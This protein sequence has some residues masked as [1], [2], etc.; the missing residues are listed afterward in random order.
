MNKLGFLPEGKVRMHLTRIDEIMKGEIWGF[1]FQP[2]PG[3]APILR[4][5]LIR[6]M[7]SMHDADTAL[8]RVTLGD[9]SQHQLMLTTDYKVDEVDHTN[10]RYKIGDKVEEDNSLGKTDTVLDDDEG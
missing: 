8:C 7:P 6:K 5:E 1:L 9:G 2:N 4:T 3:Q 10:V